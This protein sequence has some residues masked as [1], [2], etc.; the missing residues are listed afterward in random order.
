M[1]NFDTIKS[2]TIE[3]MAEWLESFATHIANEIG[4]ETGTEYQPRKGYL[5]KLKQ[6]LI[7]ESEE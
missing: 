5:W 2:M 1:R 6:W 7:G 4:K 3:E